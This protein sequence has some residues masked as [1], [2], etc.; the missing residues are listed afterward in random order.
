[1]YYYISVL[2]VLPLDNQDV[3]F[4]FDNGTDRLLIIWPV[5]VI[6]KIEKDSPFWRMSKVDLE[7]ENFEL[8]IVLEGKVTS[9]S[10]RASLSAVHS[11]RHQ[12]N[13]IF[14][15]LCSIVSFSCKLGRSH[16]WEAI[17]SRKIFAETFFLVAII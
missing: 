15:S 6:H 16:Y 17:L 1:M 2:Q 13:I 10:W 8:I 7:R 11:L 12:S 5:I 9:L 14:I 3:N 4:G